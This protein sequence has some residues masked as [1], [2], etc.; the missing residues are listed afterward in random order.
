VRLAERKTGLFKASFS[1]H[2]AKFFPSTSGDGVPSAS[3]V[4]VGDLISRQRVCPLSVPSA[5]KCPFGDLHLDQPGIT[6]N[7]DGTT[8]I[9]IQ[10]RYLQP[11]LYQTTDHGVI[12]FM[13]ERLHYRF[14]C[15]TREFVVVQFLT[16]DA[17]GDI[18]SG[19]RPNEAFRAPALS[20]VADN[21]LLTVC[22]PS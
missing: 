16:L 7:A 3:D 11:Q 22:G 5:A 15:A 6:Q 10:V 2:Q 4:L 12:R 14:N 17:E 18:V 21:I 8:D 1:V 9:W 19:E 20:S 13:V